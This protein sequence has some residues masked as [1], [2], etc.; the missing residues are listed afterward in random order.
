MNTKDVESRF[1]ELL[2]GHP[3]MRDDWTLSKHENMGDRSFWIRFALDATT[4]ATKTR[5]LAKC[6]WPFSVM[7]TSDGKG[8]FGTT[9]FVRGFLS[10]D[11]EGSMTLTVHSPEGVFKDVTAAVPIETKLGDVVSGDAFLA[12]LSDAMKVG[13]GKLK[14][15]YLGSF[16]ALEARFKANLEALDTVADILDTFL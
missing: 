13:M 8:P 16:V 9:P 4:S 12:L 11:A 7:V 3:A 1:R 5:P 6:S 14:P 10:C 2:Q 15:M